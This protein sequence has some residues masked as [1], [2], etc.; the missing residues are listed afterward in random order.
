MGI[1]AA[2]FTVAFLLAAVQRS[3]ASYWSF[4]FPAF[5]IVAVGT[6]FEFNVVNVSMLLSAMLYLI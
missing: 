5:I 1:G 2:A 4:T 3:D 6:D